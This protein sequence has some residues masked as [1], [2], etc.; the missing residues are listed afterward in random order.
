MRLAFFG[1]FLTIL[2]MTGPPSVARSQ[3]ITPPVLECGLGPWL[4]CRYVDPLS[5]EPVTLASFQI[6]HPFYEGLAAVRIDGLWGFVNYT[7]AIVV[8]PQF[9]EV[10][11]FRHGLAEVSDGVSVS[12]IDKSGQLVLHT[13]F[14]RAIPISPTVVMAFIDDKEHAAQLGR[15]ARS[16]APALWRTPQEENVFNYTDATLFGF[17]TGRIETP[18]MRSIQLIPNATDTFWLQVSE[19]GDGWSYNDWGMMN[20]AGDW[21]ISPGI[22]DVIPLPDGMSLIYNP[23]AE[24]ERDHNGRTSGQDL[25]RN[26]LGWEAIVDSNGNFLGGQYFDDVNVSVDMHPLVWVN[27]SWNEIDQTGVQSSFDGELSQYFGRQPIPEA[28][29]LKTSP[30]MLSPILSCANDVTIFS[31]PAVRPNT[32]DEALD[33][34]WGLKDRY[35]NIIVSPQHRYITCPQHGIALVPDMD[36]REWCPVGP[37][38][39]PATLSTCQRFVWD[40]MIREMVRQEIFVSDPFENDVQFKQRELIWAQYPDLVS[41][42][43][44]VP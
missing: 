8:A 9:V 40:G 21:V 15:P 1:A 10:S 19:A 24:V 17:N 14:R 12:L 37:T 31:A 18:L 41:R 39:Q 13:D 2:A 23:P 42:P 7:G 25:I 29:N 27:D 28:P 11:R 20:A 5:Q 44:W 22:M 16:L 34:R 30:F 4:M 3:Q 35:G 6:A 26:H 32:I 43:N 33:L 38:E 36:R